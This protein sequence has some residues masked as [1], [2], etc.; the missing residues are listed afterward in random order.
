MPIKVKDDAEDPFAT[1]K[2]AVPNSATVTPAIP[3]APTTPVAP[4]YGGTPALSTTSDPVT[5]G[6]TPLN[7]NYSGVSGSPGSTILNYNPIASSALPP[8]LAGGNSTTLSLAGTT[9]GANPNGA[10]V[11]MTNNPT[12]SPE[13]PTAPTVTTSPL[14]PAPTGDVTNTYKAPTN[15]D[16]TTT[17]QP[18]ENITVG[19]IGRPDITIPPSGGGSGGGEVGGAGGTGGT[20]TDSTTNRLLDAQSQTEAQV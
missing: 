15:N 18:G 6:Q 11:G 16:L 7:T 9:G 3:A 5:L 20:T 2:P 12:S 8:V 4:V 14:T 13:K 17:I 10:G 19:N 1:K